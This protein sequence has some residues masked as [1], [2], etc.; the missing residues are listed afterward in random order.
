MINE[1][2]PNMTPKRLEWLKELELP[3]N[4]MSPKGAVPSHCR[5]L[6]WTETIY[7]PDFTCGDR[8]TAA[9]REALLVHREGK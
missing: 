7:N 2:K 3:E 6:G 8:L 4:V 5:Q 1:P 9:G